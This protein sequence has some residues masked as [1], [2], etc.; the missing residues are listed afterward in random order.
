MDAEQT[1]PAGVSRRDLMKKAAVAGGL[2]WVAP[3]VLASPAFAGASGCPS[4]TDGANGQLFGIKF[5]QGSNTCEGPG[6]NPGGDGNCGAQAGITN[7]RNG[8]CLITAGLITKSDSSGGMNFVIAAGLQFCNAFAKCGN[9]CFTNDAQK[10]TVTPGANGA[11]NVRI[12]C[13]GDQQGLSHIEL[14]VCVNGTTIPA[15]CN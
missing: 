11:T 5:Q 4:C 9:T 12:D 8:C 6:T 2:V 1:T 3:T 10:I 15:G 13:D 14:F 7:F